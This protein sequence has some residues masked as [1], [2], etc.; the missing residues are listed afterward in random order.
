MESIIQTLTNKG[1]YVTFLNAVTD[2]DLTAT[3]ES[4][5][6]FTIFAPTDAAFEDMSD[7]QLKKLFEDK[8]N[9]TT[10]LSYHL[11][12]GKFMT[13]D[14][15]KLD[16]LKTLEGDSLSVS[17]IDTAIMI[18]DAQIVHPDILAANGV[19]QGIDTVISP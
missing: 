13:K 18:D 19:I 1:Q 2:V 8:I 12:P 16:S 11:V 6:I 4:D 15:L 17:H 7:S 14:L 10:I 3:L 5:G 9:L